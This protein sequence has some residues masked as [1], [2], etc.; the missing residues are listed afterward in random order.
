M[1]TLTHN[2]AIMLTPEQAGVIQ[3]AMQ[4]YLL[5]LRLDRA[6]ERCMVETA[7][8]NV[9]AMR[10]L[11]TDL[12]LACEVLEALDELRLP[13]DDATRQLLVELEGE[14]REQVEHEESGA[15][16]DDDLALAKARALFVRIARERADERAGGDA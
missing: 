14:A 10:A 11:A 8:P 7:R 1:A 15:V 3:G 9:L 2:D 5:G 12:T 6:H 16:H 13:V 4:G